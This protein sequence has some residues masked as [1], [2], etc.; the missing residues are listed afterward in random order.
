MASGTT[1]SFDLPKSKGALIFYDRA[2]L[3]LTLWD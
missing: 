3:G 1:R 2:P